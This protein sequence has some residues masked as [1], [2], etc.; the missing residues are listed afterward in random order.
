MFSIQHRQTTHIQKFETTVQQLLENECVLDIHGGYTFALVQTQNG[1]YGLGRGDV[2]QMPLPSNTYSTP[3]LISELS[4]FSVQSIHCGGYHTYLKLTNGEYW[5]FGFNTDR[6][7]ILG[8][9][10]PEEYQTTP[11]RLS[12]LEELNI[13]SLACGRWHTVAVNNKGQVFTWG[14]S[15]NEGHC[16]QM[17]GEHST[18]TKPTLLPVPAK[19]VKAFASCYSCHNF[20]LA[21]NGDLY[22]YGCNMSGELGVSER[23]LV[24]RYQDLGDIETICMSVSFSCLILRLQSAMAIKRV[25]FFDV[26]I[27]TQ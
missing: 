9:R 5:G 24:C 17:Y 22:G 3:T 13:V 19:I 27:K 12:N 6:E 20:M 23:G 18:I 7:G 14:A 15:D 26:S 16:G 1:I 4:N 11:V 2:A 10:T 25:A 21:E 8:T